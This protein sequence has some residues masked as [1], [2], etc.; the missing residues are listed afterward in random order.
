MGFLYLGAKEKAA[1]GYWKGLGAVNCTGC[2]TR[3]R[4]EK[5]D[6]FWSGNLRL[7]SSGSLKT[8]ETCIG[9]IHTCCK[10]GSLWL[11]VMHPEPSFPEMMLHV[12]S[13]S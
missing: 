4:P 10:Q 6:E 1:V 3:Q 5:E 8:E 13:I 9:N 11:L 2:S 12:F 7:R